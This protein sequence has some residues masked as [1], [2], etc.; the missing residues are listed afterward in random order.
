MKHD[1]EK[2][3]SRRLEFLSNTKAKNAYH[4]NA[5][6]K[7]AA[8]SRY[9]QVENEEGSLLLNVIINDKYIEFINLLKYPEEIDC[10]L[11]S[12]TSDELYAL[13]YSILNSG[14][15]Y[16]LLEYPKSYFEN[17]LHRDS[18]TEVHPDWIGIIHQC[19]LNYFLRQFKEFKG[20]TRNYEEIIIQL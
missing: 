20:H 6:N 17:Y 9:L 14:F 7:S 18:A 3:Q 4:L 5:L 19:L 11:Y 2:D 1:Q 10:L 15:D 16:G 12:T 13:C 8:L